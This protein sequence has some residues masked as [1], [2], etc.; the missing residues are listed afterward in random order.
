M[1]SGQFTGTF[2]YSVDDRGRVPIPPRF[3]DAFE[4]GIWVARSLD[5]C[6]EV[7]TQAGW[8]RRAAEVE[9][10]PF[11]DPR[12]RDLRRLVAGGA[13]RAEIDRQGR[14][15]LP[16][17]LRQHAGITGAAVYVGVFDSI[18]LWSA[19][20]WNAKD[21]QILTNPPQL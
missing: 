10:L 14:I 9:A 16:P 8:E 15:L 4:T 1:P 19:D 20:R 18:E 5:P 11:T 7:Y 12:A 13:F 6:L 17:P 2:E 3:R 21:Q